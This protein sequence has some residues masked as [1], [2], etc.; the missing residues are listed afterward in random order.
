MDN[1]CEDSIVT[2]GE[3]LEAEQ[4]MIEDANAVLGAGD[5]KNCTYTEGYMKRQ[6]L[7]ACLTCIPEAKEDP[8]KR[9]GICLACC[10]H[11]HDGH[12]LIELYTKRNFRCDCGNSKFPANTCNLNKAKDKENVLNNYNQN[13]SGVYCTCSRP[14]PDPEDKVSDEM[15]QCVICEDWYHT[16]H[17]DCKLP[18]MNSYAEM[19]CRSCVEKHQFLLHYDNLCITVPKDAGDTPVEVENT[20]DKKTDDLN[21]SKSCDD[22][23]KIDETNE[24]DSAAKENEKDS[25]AKENEKVSENTEK[26]DAIIENNEKENNIKSHEETKPIEEN[27]AVETEKKEDTN[28]VEAEKEKSLKHEGD[29]EAVTENEEKVC[30]KPKEKSEN[31]CAKFWTNVNW[32]QQLCTCTECFNM[33]KEQNILFLIDAGDTVQSYEEKGKAKSLENAQKVEEDSIKFLNSVNRIPLMETLAAY[34]DL[35]ENLTDY[36]K[37]FAENKKVVRE[38][39]IR[40]FFSEFESRKKQ[41]VEIPSMC[42]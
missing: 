22:S 27:G 9:A 2:L 5:D 8:S 6:P 7:Y 15:I 24:K 13:F 12:D 30:I 38:E 21:E 3:V 10:Y 29:G 42:R 23:Q 36:L 28:K 20:E 37:K 31:I 39:D 32:R 41:K 40:E 34:N 14:Y 26:N 25:A 33:Y 18:P 1:S 4:E 17:L 16:R 35:K 19:T 11:C